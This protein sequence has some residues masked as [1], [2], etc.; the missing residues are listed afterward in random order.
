MTNFQY[1][2]LASAGRPHGRPSQRSVDR[3]AQNVHRLSR[4]TTRELLLSENGPVDRAFNRQAIA[5]L[6]VDRPV[7]RPSLTV[8][9]PTVGGRPGGRPTAVQTAELASNGQIFGAY[10]L[11]LPWAVFGKIFWR[12]SKPVF[13]IY[14]RGF[15]HLFQSKYFHSK[16]EFIKRFSKVIL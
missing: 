10:K 9:N 13:P 1:T 15:L 3:R 6:A 7:D 14:C 8:G 12:V 4:S 2:V 5:Q 16:G 11:G